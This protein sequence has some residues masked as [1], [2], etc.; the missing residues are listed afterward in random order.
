MKRLYLVLFL[1]LFAFVIN[2][3]TFTEKLRTSNSRGGVIVLQQSAMID[4]LVNG[5]KLKLQKKSMTLPI[6]SQTTDSTSVD[7]LQRPEVKGYLDKQG[8]RI[9]I[10][11][12]SNSRESKTTALNLKQRSLKLFPDMEAY[13]SFISP[14]WVVRIGDFLNREQAMEQLIKVRESGLSREVRLVRCKIKVPIY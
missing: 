13:C 6:V 2:A 8:Y 7:S 5:F 11:T 4:S 10:Y 14:R 12:G 1:S 3:Q 9:Q